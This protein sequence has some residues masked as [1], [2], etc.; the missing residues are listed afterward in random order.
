M[1]DVVGTFVCTPMEVIGV[2]GNTGVVEC[3]EIGILL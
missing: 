3:I 1:E 2:L